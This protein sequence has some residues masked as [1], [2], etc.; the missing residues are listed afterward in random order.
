MA[1]AARLVERGDSNDQSAAAGLLGTLDEPRDGLAVAE[2]VQLKPKW[3]RR[4]GSDRAHRVVALGWHDKNRASC[5]GAG[6]GDLGVGVG[7]PL[8]G[9]RAEQHRKCDRLTK[10]L[11]GEITC[12]NIDE[13]ARTQLDRAKG[14]AILC[15]GA[16][17][18]RA[19]GVV[20]P[21]RLGQPLT[22]QRLVVGEIDRV[23]LRTPQSM[24]YLYD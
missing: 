9:R 20:I 14:L 4:R 11:R 21:S 23:R 15:D 17:V 3:S 10:H 7:Q 6:A 2:C 8:V 5:R 24:D 1:L 18:L 22:S 12:A 16:L 13:H 19:A